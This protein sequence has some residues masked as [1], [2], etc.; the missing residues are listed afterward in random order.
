MEEDIK[1]RVANNLTAL[2]KNKNLT[3]SDV[4]KA[5]NYSDKSVSKWEHADSLPDISILSRLC[6]MYG[7]T[8]DYLI[9][10][11]AEEQIKY[12]K[13]QQA[14]QKDRSYIIT[15]ILMSISVVYLIATVAF[16]YSILNSSN[17]FWEAFIWGLPVCSL[18]MLYCSRKWLKL[19]VLNPIFSSLLSW[20]LLLSIYL[21]FFSYN[22]WL[23][24][25]IGIPIQ[26]IIIL[27][28]RLNRK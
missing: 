4:A 5:L 9:H 1:V 25:I 23:I 13:E 8:I 2:R 22:M 24:F 19:K 15:T 26:I 27:G 21:Q 14:N 12:I 7:V 10:E 11:N 3:Q 20:S 28:M 17:A 6:D 18:I 16:V